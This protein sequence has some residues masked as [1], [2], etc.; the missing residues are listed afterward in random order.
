MKI[1]ELR[2]LLNEIL[3]LEREI[4]VLLNKEP[5]DVKDEI[6]TAHQRH[7]LEWEQLQLIWKFEGKDEKQN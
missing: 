3:R 4:S 6:N 5:F 2:T 7:D 1:L